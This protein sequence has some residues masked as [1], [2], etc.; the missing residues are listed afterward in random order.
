MSES[1]KWVIED[2]VEKGI[3]WPNEEL[4]KRVRE[5]ERKDTEIEELKKQFALLSRKFDELGTN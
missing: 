4:K 2:P 1:T 3:F 5:L